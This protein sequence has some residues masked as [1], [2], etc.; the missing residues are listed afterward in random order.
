MEYVRSKELECIGA[1]IIGGFQNTK[2]L[3]V[4]KYKE[5]MDTND[6]YDQ[7]SAVEEEHNKIEKYDVWAPQKI[8]DLTTDAKIITSTWAMKK[9]AYDT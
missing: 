6:K 7:E 5:K 8:Q 2:E 4:I 1:V 9:K 3:H